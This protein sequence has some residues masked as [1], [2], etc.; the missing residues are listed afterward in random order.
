MAGIVNGITDGAKGL[1][2]GIVGTVKDIAVVWRDWQDSVFATARGI[3]MTREQAKGLQDVLMKNQA[4]LS[5]LYGLTAREMNDFQNGIVATTGRAIVLNRKQM[6]SMA[7][8]RNLMNETGEGG[9]Q[10]M[11]Q[12]IGAMQEFGISIDD[13]MVHVTMLQEKAAEFGLSAQQASE[14]LAKNVQLAQS[15]TF[16]NGIDGLAA[17]ALRARQMRVDIQAIVSASDKFQ[18]I[19]DSIKNSANVQ[20]LGGTFAMNFSNP[21]AVMAD[22][23]TNQEAFGER[24]INALAGKGT[25]NAKTGQVDLSPIDRAMIKQFAQSV[26]MNANDAIK[27]AMASAQNA[28]VDQRVNLNAS[29]GM[30]SDAQRQWI[31][32]NAQWNAEAQ[33]FTVTGIDKNGEMVESRVEDLTPDM[34]D[35]MRSTEL[36]EENMMADVSE[37]NDNVRKLAGETGR[38]RAQTVLS[39][40][41]NLSGAKNAMQTSAA[42]LFTPIANRVSD[43][44]NAG[45]KTGTAIDKMTSNPLTAAAGILGVDALK[46]VFQSI[47]GSGSGLSTTLGKA[48]G[49]AGAFALAAYASG[50]S[51]EDMFKS[52]TGTIND[53][54]DELL[55][56]VE[57]KAGTAQVFNEEEET[58]TLRAKNSETEKAQAKKEKDKGKTE[59][60]EDEEE[61]E[62]KAKKETGTKVRKKDKAKGRGRT[63]KSSAKPKK[64]EE[65]E[66]ETEETEEE[67]TE[68]T[69]TVES[70]KTVTETAKAKT[71]TTVAKGSETETQATAT[72]QPAQTETTLTENKA[73]PATAPAVSEETPKATG[74]ASAQESAEVAPS[75]SNGGVTSPP[76]GATTTTIYNTYNYNYGVGGGNGEVVVRLV[77]DGSIGIGGTSVKGTDMALDK[78]ESLRREVL[79]LV[80]SYISEYDYSQRAFT[81]FGTRYNRPF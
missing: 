40:R 48:A 4:E 54:A 67:S 7:I 79:D 31:R 2:S 63:K 81:P 14:A 34:L 20:M 76:I 5:R 10:S 13:T 29:A 24:I 15:Y 53:A 21:M 35:S 59:E 70:E 62:T 30:F 78:N 47:T 56:G 23:L 72:A 49:A 52:V 66:I 50:E 18:N 37:I 73:T 22:A 64:T 45:S 44:V 11:I 71:T 27:M 55:H 33:T 17:M 57:K 19:E 65:T 1:L 25:W 77:V 26:G 75:A 58:K 3:G 42:R 41:Q 80:K 74:S 16:R 38:T 43:M 6:E 12:L 32:S 28:A 51:L 8:L 69:T 60:E 9:G 36:T 68:T 61:E 46:S 39:V